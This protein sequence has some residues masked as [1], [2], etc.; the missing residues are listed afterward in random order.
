MSFSNDELKIINELS[1]LKR[2]KLLNRIKE[3]STAAWNRAVESKDINSW[4]AN[5]TGDCL[6]DQNA[7]QYLALWLLENFV[8]YTESDIR[9][10]T[11]NMWWKYLHFQLASFEATGFLK[12]KDLA[13]KVNFFLEATSIQPLGN[14]SGSGT[15]IAYYFRQSNHL[16]SKYF[17]VQHI[18]DCKYLVLLDDATLSGHQAEENLAQ[19]NEYT[20]KDIYILTCISSKS[21][22]THLGDKVTLLSAI[23]IDEKSKC[24]DI[25]SYVFRL[26]PDWSPLAKKMCAHYGHKL[27]PRN[28]L[29]YRKGQYTF[30]FFYNIPNNSLPIFWGTLDGWVP[31]FTRYFSEEQSI[32]EAEDEK[33]L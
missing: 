24:F 18:K 26:H 10:L 31:L 28:P 3:I 5:F 17:E 11:K 6:D 9:T 27:D 19:Y 7:E 32:G 21:A 8:F 1:K 20:D 14:C 2:D 22:K 4:L 25:N 12:E 23:E 16:D 15:N 30:S 29:G 33:F 13:E